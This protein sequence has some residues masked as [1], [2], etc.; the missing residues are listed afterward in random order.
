MQ[1]ISAAAHIEFMNKIVDVFLR[2]VYKNRVRYLAI[3]EPT[4][5]N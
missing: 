3:S 4:K 5:K 1:L 2:Y